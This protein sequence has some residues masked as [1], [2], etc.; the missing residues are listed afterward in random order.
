MVISVLREHIADQNVSFVFPSQIASDLWAR[1]TCTLGIVRSVA[2]GRFLAWDRF[3]EEVVKETTQ[4]EVSSPSTSVMRRIFADALVRKNAKDPFLKSLIP[5]EYS[6]SGAVFAPFI[7]RLLPSLAYWEKLANNASSAGCLTAVD[8]E[9]G[10]YLLVKKEYQAF[11]ERYGLFEPSWEQVKTLNGSRR[12]VIFFPELIEDFAEYDALLSGTQFIRVG[13]ETAANTAGAP[14]LVFYQSAREEIRSAVM[15]IQKYHEVDGVPYEDMAI[16][17]PETEEMEPYLLLELSLRHVPH[18]R[19]AGKKLGE[20][21]AGRLF[22]LVNEAASSRFSFNSLKALVLSDHIPWSESE[23]NKA[24]VNFG[25]KYNCVSG[26]SQD[27]RSV[28]IWEEAFKEACGRG[29]R[30]E[31]IELQRYYWKL[32][33]A[34][35]AIAGAESF[36]GIK[37][38]YFD[39]WN[40]FNKSG[41][42]DMEKISPEDDAVLSRC[43]AELNNLIELEERFND[44]ALVP[45]S[46]LGFLISHLDEIVYVRDDKKTGV[47]I[48][49]WRAAAA[50]P[51]R[52]HFVLNASQSA[53]SVIYQPLKFLRQDKRKHLGLEDKDA[54]GAFFLLCNSGDND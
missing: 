51:F 53:A 15:E 31:N 35:F 28:D 22:S 37:K 40:S 10:D 17:I 48:Y 50:S 9:D 27:G 44:P 41:L 46:P 52:C 2:K 3:K 23:K 38:K 20:S 33:E 32:K 34:V 19:R 16:S 30:A 26:Y 42:L 11:L 13:A 21:G 25:I 5:I 14:L 18:V 1:K 45:S 6:G 43:I 4:G 54:T 39:F 12:Y 7:A 47:N 49:P 36:G 29:Q 24:L 8:A